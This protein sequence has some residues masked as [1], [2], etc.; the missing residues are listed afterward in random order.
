M[1][2]LK[3]RLARELKRQA[4][5][6]HADEARDHQRA[7]SHRKAQVHAAVKGLIWTTE[8]EDDEAERLEDALA[9]LLADDTL[10]P[11]FL[12]LPLPELV[13]RLCHDLD[14]P[15]PSADATSLPAAH[16]RE[17]GDPSGLGG[18]PYESS[19]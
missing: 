4:R 16:P 12:T 3:V 17:G 2:A 9:E 18:P 19:A 14:L 10:S 8:R 5:E 11:D 15:T 7:V 6:D 13:A 1:L